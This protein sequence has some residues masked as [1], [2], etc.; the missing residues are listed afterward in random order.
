MTTRIKNTRIISRETERFAYYSPFNDA[1]LETDFQNAIRTGGLIS[2]GNQ[3]D[4]TEIN[5]YR[6][7][8]EIAQEA[9]RFMGT[10]PKIWAGNIKGC[11]TIQTIGQMLSFVEFENT[12]MFEERI[13]FDPV[14][15]IESDQHEDL[16]MIFNDGPQQNKE[17]RI[18]VFT[19]PYTK[20]LDSNEAL[21][22][23]HDIR[24]S[25]EDGNPL[26]GY[27]SEKNS[28]IEQFFDFRDHTLP[29]FL[30]SGEKFFGQYLPGSGFLNIES[31]DYAFYRFNGDRVNQLGTLT[32][33][34][35]STLT[36]LSGPKIDKPPGNNETQ[37]LA[38]RQDSGD[39]NPTSLLNFS[40]TQTRQIDFSAQALIWISSSI[41]DTVNFG[42]LSGSKTQ[43]VN[44][45]TV[46]ST[47]LDVYTGSSMPIS[48]ISIMWELAID[49]RGGYLSGGNYIQTTT[50]KLS[51]RD[52]EQK[53]FVSSGSGA[54]FDYVLNELNYEI[55]SGSN[56]I[57][58]L[59]AW[60][61]VAFARTSSVSDTSIYAHTTKLYVNGNKVTESQGR[62][63]AF[64][65]ASS[66]GILGV[67]IAQLIS[68]ETGS[69]SH[70]DLFISGTVLTTVLPITGFDDLRISSLK[71]TNTIPSDSDIFSTAQLVP[72]LNRSFSNYYMSGVYLFGHLQ[73]SFPPLPPYE[74]TGNYPLITE[75]QTDN[76]DLISILHTSTSL[77]LD[78]DLRKRY[79]IKSTPAGQDVYGPK[80]ARYGT[81]SIAYS[82]YLRGSG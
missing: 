32:L 65:S 60:N 49:K 51:Y 78:D 72:F 52:V 23:A 20:G 33:T 44:I 40:N 30:E 24:A 2:S 16:E 29:P 50:P 63:H 58:N 26:W 3:I 12:T 55:T 1:I 69:V 45:G 21:S 59:N 70:D 39:G 77:N 64:L 57:W 10:G 46:I 36:F 80:Q 47:S 25:L 31:T 43:R 56:S 8:I 68:T 22:N 41:L 38:I 62:H 66:V 35:Q 28:Q 15:Y 61:H 11:V 13:R 37:A 42:S 18:D 53:G 67:G 17:T 4:T 9:Y 14:S 76:S 73:D 48:P 19:S 71:F 74:D 34:P 6:Q 75:L 5:Q 7:G 81:D 79:G 82:G 54:V 27:V